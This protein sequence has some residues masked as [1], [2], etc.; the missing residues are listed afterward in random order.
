MGH[1][2]YEITE[3]DILFEGESLIE[4]EADERARRACSSRSSTRLRSPA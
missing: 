1:P 3:G 2:T 4:L